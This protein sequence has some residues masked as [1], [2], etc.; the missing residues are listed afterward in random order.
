MTFLMCKLHVFMQELVV[1]KTQGNLQAIEYIQALQTKGHTQRRSILL[2]Y[3]G[4]IGG[5]F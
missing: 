3:T 2:N 5:I 4:L 1:G